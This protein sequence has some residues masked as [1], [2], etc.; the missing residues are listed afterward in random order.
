RRVHRHGCAHPG[1]EGVRTAA[2]RLV[3]VS[4]ARLWLAPVGETHV[5]N[6]GE[7]MFPPRTPFFRRRG[8]TGEPGVPPCET[9]PLLRNG[10][11][12]SRFPLAPSP[13]HRP[14]VGL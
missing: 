8:Y 5:S 10:G 3:C 11:G 13:A 4:V 2:G 9:S 6:V 1:G 12:T 7:T 14:K